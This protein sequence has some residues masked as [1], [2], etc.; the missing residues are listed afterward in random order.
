MPNSKAFLPRILIVLLVIALAVNLPRSVAL[1]LGNLSL[2]R[3]VLQE[4]LSAADSAKL[5]LEYSAP[6][7]AS[8]RSLTR[9]YLAQR[10]TAK[11]ITAGEQAVTLQSRDL[12]ASYWLGQAYWM[13]GEKDA[14]RRI[15]RAEGII[16]EKLNYYGWLC[17]QFAGRGEYEQAETALR[18]AMDLDPEWGPAYDALA[19]LQWGRDW[20]KVSWALD[21]AIAYLPEGTALWYW[22]EGRQQLMNGNWSE[23][24]QSLGKAADLQPTEWTLR[25]LMDA[26]EKLGDS[27]GAAKTQ[28]ELER[29]LNGLSQ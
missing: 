5:W 24:S 27:I 29:L 9:L 26:L 18:E 6:S 1:N 21:R 7:A 3:V 8:Y 4:D 23:A 12:M 17:W 19:S 16:Q 14:S 20:Q 10:Q 15:W 2:S 28:A 13:A 11:A 22:N 25:F